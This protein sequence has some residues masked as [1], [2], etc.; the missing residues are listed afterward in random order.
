MI[1]ASTP[2]FVLIFAYLFGI[3]Q[4]T[5][6]L[7][8]V[9][10]IIALGEYFTVKGEVHF[11]RIGFILCIAASLLSGARWTLVQLKLQTL[12]P[13]LKTTI[14]TM[15]LLSPSMFVSL[16]IFSIIFEKP[17][18]K[19]SHESMEQILVSFGLGMLGAVL[20]IAMILCE[21][22][23]IMRANAIILMIGGVVKEMISIFIGVMF[24]HDTLNGTNVS[25][26]FIVLLGVVFY[27]VIH[28]IE[29][30]RDAHNE[31]TR[32]ATSSDD[33]YDTEID[34]NDDHN[35]MNGGKEMLIT[36]PKSMSRS[37]FHD[38][39]NKYEKINSTGNSSNGD[40]DGD[41]ER[42]N[43]H[44]IV[45]AI[46]IDDL[47]LNSLSHHSSSHSNR[48]YDGIELRR[49]RSSEP[50]PQRTIRKGMNGIASLTID[51]N[52]NNER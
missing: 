12:D 2:I 30:Q 28:Y 41:S 33:M 36:S 7:L 25:G 17:W 15:K 34:T 39:D 26:C 31:M 8:M 14:A 6:Q 1:K 47:L 19:L 3:E 52:M 35:R 22:Y 46:H 4:I 9:V 32:I 42:C 13:P 29:A 43:Q 38:D 21:F 27:K 5:P 45:T 51:N 49:N 40:L 20:A 24:F 44:S 10:F 23:L 16:F 18:A 11:D 48:R 37:P 50:S